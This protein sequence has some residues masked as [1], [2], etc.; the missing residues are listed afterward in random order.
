MLQVNIIKKK[1][2]KHTP[3]T[4]Y[5][6]IYHSHK[7]ECTT[8]GIFYLAT[9]GK[10]TAAPNALLALVVFYDDQLGLEQ[11]GNKRKKIITT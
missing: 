10:T 2:Q 3:I 4:L 6:H 9:I 11:F 7:Y 1:F 5:Y 8:L